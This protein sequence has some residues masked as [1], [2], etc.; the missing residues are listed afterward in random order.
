MF[1]VLHVLYYGLDNRMRLY[2]REG[3][4][5]GDPL[6]M[7]LY[8]AGTLPLVQKVKLENVTQTWYAD[9]ASACAKLEDLLQWFKTMST[10]GPTYGYYP[11]PHKCQVIVDSAHFAAAHNI[12]TSSY[13][14]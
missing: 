10:E 4:A 3:V 14:P 5:Q 6:S 1:R 7:F 8:A 2:S 12:R 9:D 11:Q 13:F